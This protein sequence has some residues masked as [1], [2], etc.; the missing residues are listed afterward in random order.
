MNNIETAMIEDYKSGGGFMDWVKKHKKELGLTAAAISSLAALAGALAVAHKVGEKQRGYPFEASQTPLPSPPSSALSPAQSAR[1]LERFLDENP[2]KLIPATPILQPRRII[3]GDE[4][5]QSSSPFGVRLPETPPQTPVLSSR[6]IKGRGLK[7]SGF[8]KFLKKHKTK[9]GISAGLLSALGIG[10]IGAYNYRKNDPARQ[11]EEAK[12]RY[13]DTPQEIERRVGSYYNDPLPESELYSGLGAKKCKCGT[14]ASKIMEYFGPDHLA[15]MMIQNPKIG[16]GIISDL[17]SGITKGFNLIG[18]TGLSV[19]V[20]LAVAI[21]GPLSRPFV[22]KLIFKYGM[23]GLSFIKKNAHKGL[24]WIKNNVMDTL[25]G[26]EI[27]KPKKTIKGKGACCDMCK[28]FY[29]NEFMK[30]N[31][32]GK[33]IEKIGGSFTDDLASGVIWLGKKVIAPVARIMP[34]SLGEALAYGPE[35]LEQIASLTSPDFK[36]EDPFAEEEQKPAYLGAYVA[37]SAQ[38]K[39]FKDKRPAKKDITA[40]PFTGS[41]FFEKLMALVPHRLVNSMIH[42]KMREG[43]H[44]KS[45]KSDK[46]GGKSTS[47]KI[48][49]LIPWALLHALFQ[50]VLDIPSVSILPDRMLDKQKRDGSYKEGDGMCGGLPNPFT[51]PKNILHDVPRP[52]PFRDPKNF[53]HDVPRPKPKP[54]KPVEESEMAYIQPFPFNPLDGGR[55]IMMPDHPMYN[56][57]FNPKQPTQNPNFNESYQS[58]VK[59][60]NEEDSKFELPKAGAGRK[61]KKITKKALK[62]ILKF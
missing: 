40:K 54:K 2:P 19:L 55:K 42:E 49:K 43:M 60:I 8:V 53:L 20:E 59:N 44:R 46:K 52:N 5:K 10:A 57:L 29:E 36:Y 58:P 56:N 15:Q 50:E 33:D 61:K 4:S 22:N 23:K 30:G 41:G 13:E 47:K 18:K 11:R 27:E 1:S 6:R 14:C 34:G 16:S 51:N 45:D 37:P 48:Y 24:T 12:E 32:R 25:K 62:N 26:E 9:L 35:H 39:P 7:D 21:L 31:I 3:H 17:H 38:P 28:P